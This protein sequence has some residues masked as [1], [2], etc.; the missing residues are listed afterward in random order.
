MA[1]WGKSKMTLAEEDEV[2]N[3]PVGS[4]RTGGRSARVRQAVLESALLELCDVGH[5][6]FNISNVA[7]RAAVHETTVYRRWPQKEALISDA[8]MQ[9]A[10]MQLPVPDTGNL[11]NDLRIVLGNIARS[12]DTPIGRAL[13]ALGFAMRSMPEYQTFGTLFWR[14]R[15]EIGQQVFRQAIARGEWPADY[16]QDEVFS[17]L[18]GPL[19]AMYFLLQVPITPAMIEQRIQ[20]VI[21]FGKSEPKWGLEF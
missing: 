2:E 18:I 1:N 15:I 20:F 16:H 19:L 21:A 12:L 9:Y 6:A 3:S 17:E 7:K 13:V 4:R 11:A 14:K 5:A 8:C 10:D